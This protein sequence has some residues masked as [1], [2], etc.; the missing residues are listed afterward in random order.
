MPTARDRRDLPLFSATSC[1]IL[2]TQRVC[3]KLRVAQEFWRASA[4]FSSSF[5]SWTSRVRI[6]SPAFT[7]TL[8]G[9]VSVPFSLA[10][11]A[12]SASESVEAFDDL[13]D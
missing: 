9:I 8:T 4:G 5:P 12:L 10:L 13:I 2:H 6:A 1:I 7:G 11:R 3:R